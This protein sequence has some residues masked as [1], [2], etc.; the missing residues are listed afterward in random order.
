MTNEVRRNELFILECYFLDSILS[1]RT[2][3]PAK[4]R[5]NLCFERNEVVQLD[6]K[7]GRE[8]EREGEE[9]RKRGRE[10]ER[11]E[12]SNAAHSLSRVVLIGLVV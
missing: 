7:R 11:N 2:D 9:G 6:R 4:A 12:E 5:G 8:R 1:L 3:N 10:G